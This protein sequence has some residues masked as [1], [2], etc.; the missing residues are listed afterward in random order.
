[1]FGMPSWDVYRRTVPDGFGH[2]GSLNVLSMQ[3]GKVSDRL[4]NIEL[5]AV[6]RWHLSDWKWHDLVLG[7][8]RWILSHRNRAVKSNILSAL[9]SWQILHYCW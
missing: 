6:R 8:Y 3:H 5:L 9:R 1:M 7:L 2:D 4:S